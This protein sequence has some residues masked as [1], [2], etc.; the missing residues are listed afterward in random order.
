[1]DITCCKN[2]GIF[3]DENAI[4]VLTK[5]GYRVTL[6]GKDVE[7]LMNRVVN[8]KSKLCR[9]SDQL[10]L[11]FAV[12]K[13]IDGWLDDAAGI[14]QVDESFF[15]PLLANKHK[16][17]YKISGQHSSVY[18]SRYSIDYSCITL[19][20]CAPDGQSGM[21]AM[22]LPTLAGMRS[23]LIEKVVDITDPSHPVLPYMNMHKYPIKI[24]QD[25]VER[26][27]NPSTQ[28]PSN[29]MECKIQLRTANPGVFNLWTIR[30]YL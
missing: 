24:D 29:T 23:D 1:M 6:I 14:R 28:L 11:V 2:M 13:P 7:A 4:D 15:E 12:T 30:I 10:T 19:I 27:S 17:L 22:H 9:Y 18:A 25:N 3:N 26:T 21:N 16:D 20:S 5:K 8:P